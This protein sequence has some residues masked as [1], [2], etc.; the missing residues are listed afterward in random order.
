[1][2]ER[3]LGMGERALSPGR[4]KMKVVRAIDVVQRHTRFGHASR[5]RPRGAR[6]VLDDGS[7]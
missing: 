5:L 1:M 4:V 6:H 7:R 3:R 2:D